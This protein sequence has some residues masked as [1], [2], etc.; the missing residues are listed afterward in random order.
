[1]AT[2]QSALQVETMARQLDVR[3]AKFDGTKRHLPSR[4]YGQP[5][6]LAKIRSNLT[7]TSLI[8]QDSAELA[9]FCGTTQALDSVSTRR[10]RPE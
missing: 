2:Y 10:K 8:A 1:M 4:R 7:F 5:V 6:D 9:H 3:I